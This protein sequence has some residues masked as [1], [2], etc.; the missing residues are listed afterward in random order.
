MAWL[1]GAVFCPDRDHLRRALLEASGSDR[2]AC[3][4]V[5]EGIA[6]G[7]RNAVE[8]GLR[9]ARVRATRRGKARVRRLEQ[10]LRHNWEGMIALPEA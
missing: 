3:E 8:E 10:Y 4:R 6:R 5:A 9:E 2:E 7:D 1:P